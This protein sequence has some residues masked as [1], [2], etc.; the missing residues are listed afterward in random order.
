MHKLGR[1]EQAMADMP[2]HNSGKVGGDGQKQACATAQDQGAGEPASLFRSLYDVS[3]T[4]LHI[5]PQRPVA[6]TV[7]F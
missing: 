3:P 1:T 7:C 5:G 4:C 2:H 6:Q